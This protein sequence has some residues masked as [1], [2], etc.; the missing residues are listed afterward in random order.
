[1]LSQKT[2][3]HEAVLATLAALS[4]PPAP[5]RLYPSLRPSLPQLLGWASCATAPAGSLP[6]PAGLDAAVAQARA[7][8]PVTLPVDAARYWLVAPSSWSLAAGRAPAAA[9]RRRPRRAG[10]PE[11]VHRP[12]A[13]APAGAPGRRRAR[14]DAVAAETAGAASQPFALRSERVLTPASWPWAQWLAWPPP[15]RC[16]SP[17]PPPGVAAAPRTAPTRAGPRGGHG[18]PGHAGRD[19]RGHRP[20][21]EPAADRH[22]GPD[23]RRRTHAGRRRRTARRAR[24]PAGA[25]RPA[26]RPTSS[27]AC[28]LV[29]PARPP[30]ARRWIPRRWRIRCASC[31]SRSWRARACAWRGATTPRRTP[32]GRPRG[33]GTDPAQP[34]AERRR[35]AGRHARGAAGQADRAERRG[36][37]RPLPAQRAR[38]RPRHRARGLPRLYQPF[39]TTRA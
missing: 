28:A 37:W 14:L 16:W 18:T 5:E 20:R 29:R 26:A 15:A 19:G 3:Q 25:A 10:Q 33:A 1:M 7:G 35:R 34:G 38:Q 2:V 22:P 27:P 24:G 21:A 30:R 6:P 12:R 11:P 32:A 23:P 9:G 31:A 36:G 17:A 13:A 8:R 39:Y 4:H